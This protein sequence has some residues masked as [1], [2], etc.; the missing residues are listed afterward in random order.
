MRHPL[1]QRLLDEYAYPVVTL[2][3]HE[4]FVA[5]PGISV[6]FFAGDPKRYRET[7]D[8]AVVLPELVA[9]TGQKLQPGVVATEA[10][11]ELQ[12][13]YGFRQWPTLIFTRPE[14]YLGRISRMKNWQEYIEQL[15]DIVRAIP[16]PPPGFDLPAPPAATGNGRSPAGEVQ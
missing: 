6:L 8:V 3:N 15:E 2:E 1:I 10:E 7:T 16:R 12:K 5:R 11:I 14:G 9:A 4:A 13:I